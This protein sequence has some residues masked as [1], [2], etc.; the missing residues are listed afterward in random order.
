MLGETLYTLRR[1]QGLSQEQLAEIVGVSRQTISKWEGNQSTPDLE[2]LVALADCFGVSLDTLV[3]GNQE[4]ERDTAA[5]L[6]EEKKQSLTPGM[7][8]GLVFVLVCV[9]CLAVTGMVWLLNPDAIELINSS[10]TLT[11]N[12]S[13]LIF[14][15]CVLGMMFGVYLILKKDP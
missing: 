10:S 7:L 13:G 12:G 15:L 5:P 4:Q 3:R 8:A 14:V 2:K 11:I 1:K 6:A 9:V